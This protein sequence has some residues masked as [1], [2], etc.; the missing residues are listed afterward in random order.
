MLRIANLLENLLISVDVD[1]KD[2]VVGGGGSSKTN[3]NLSKF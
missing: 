1:E 2:E 3:Q